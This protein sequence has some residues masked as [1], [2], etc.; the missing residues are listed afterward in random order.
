MSENKPIR[1]MAL[2][3]SLMLLLSG[4][5]TV[6]A[7][8]AS[9][10]AGTAEVSAGQTAVVMITLKNSGSLSGINFTLSYDTARLS[11]I[12]SAAQ[13]GN[14]ADSPVIYNDSQNGVVHYAWDSAEGNKNINGN[15]ITFQFKVESGA[16][17]GDIP[18]TVTVKE[19]Y[20][21]DISGGALKS[22]NVTVSAEN[23]KITVKG[24]D[25]AVSETIAAI[26]NIGTVTYDSD[27]LSRINNAANKYLALTY[28]QRQQVTNFDTLLAAQ[29][30]YSQLEADYKAQQAKSQADSW[31]ADNAVILAKTVEN[32]TLADKP[33][34]QAALDGYIK[35]STA[36]K[37][38]AIK[39]KNHLNI[40]NNYFAILEKIAEDAAYEA[41][42]RA[43]AEELA[44]KYRKDFAALLST[45]TD[46]VFTEQ[47]DSI[48]YAIS[49][50]DGLVMM[51]PYVKELLSGE[52]AHLNSLLA[53]IEE[54]L[55]AENPEES[56]Y[57]IEANEFKLNYSYVLS[58]SPENVTLDDALEIQVALAVLDTLE[59]ETQELLKK[60][61]AHLES[62]A[63]AVESLTEDDEDGS[64]LTDTEDGDMDELV[65]IPES[66]Y[67]AAQVKTVRV[68]SRQGF[69]PV[70]WILLCIFA[71]AS[72]AVIGLWIFYLYIKKGKEPEEDI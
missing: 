71:V 31:R 21:L 25:S 61:K 6:A 24:T 9:L 69:N 13:T 70:I 72:L 5:T 20:R 39:E 1:F 56:E 63:E 59:D 32:L 18:L 60:E 17:A 47:N 45:T 66:E 57:I 52:L 33:A 3:L 53:A 34:V 7:D 2:V 44:K 68:V 67:P 8:G 12:E 54:L 51:N 26:A 10:S 29:E 50:M 27:S 22:E 48:I 30:K 43:Q 16:A 4:F 49:E 15:F 55:K 42:L 65:I 64:S 38:D 14:G 37:A 40:L 23:G 28:T 62:L 19:A 58:L 46:K 11:Y 41:E 36:A 35:L